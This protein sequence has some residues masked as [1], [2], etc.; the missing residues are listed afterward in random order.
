MANQLISH[1][2][3]PSTDFDLSTKF[4]SHL[5][6]WDLKPFGSGYSL[7]NTQKGLTVGLRKV[8]KVNSG[9]TTI[10][11]VNVEDIEA[12]LDKINFAG[13]AIERGKTVIPV[14][15]WYALVK[16]PCGNVLGLYQSHIV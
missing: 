6:G 13:G 11:H 1:I 10:F 2:E 12:T 4:Y 5:F 14:Y 15:G 3:I 8:E 16:D 7:Y 9:D